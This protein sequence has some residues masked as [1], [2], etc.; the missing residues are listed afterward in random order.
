M[1]DIREIMKKI[2]PEWTIVNIIGEGSFATVYKAVREDLIGT[3]YAAIKVTRI[4]RDSNEIDSL[5]AEGLEPEK[6]YDYYQGVVKDYSAEIKLMD[7]VKGYTNIVAIDD[8]RIYQPEDRLIWYIFIRMELLT[9]LVKDVARHGIDEDR[10]IRLGIDLCT[11][12]DVCRQ[13]N[14]VHRDIKPENIFVN[15]NGYF[16]LGDFGVARNLEKMTNGLSLKG[17]PNYMA[18]EVAKSI[19]TEVDFNSAARID[20]Y[21]LGMVMYWLANGSK[22]PFLPL[23]KQ[24]ASPEDRKNA[25]IRRINGETL[26]LP[27]LVSPELQQII[28]KACSYDPGSRYRSAYD[29]KTALFRLQQKRE[30][31]AESPEPTPPPPPEENPPEKPPEPQPPENPPA[32]TYSRNSFAYPGGDAPGGS[33]KTR[34]GAPRKK[35][36]WLIL[37]PVL[38]LVLGVLFYPGF[39]KDDGRQGSLFDILISRLFA[40]APLPSETSRAS[41]DAA[42]YVVPGFGINRTVFSINRMDLQS[43]YREWKEVDAPFEQFP[44]RNFRDLPLIPEVNFVSRDILDY[45]GTEETNVTYFYDVIT[46]KFVQNPPADG[47]FITY[48]L[49][50]YCP[51]TNYALTRITIRDSSYYI[52]YFSVYYIDGDQ[53]VCYGISVSI[54]ESEVIDSTSFTLNYSNKSTYPDLTLTGVVNSK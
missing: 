29:M 13:H 22:L 15:D 18:P 35:K 40:A 44:Y 14:I 42:K 48:K 21:S 6:T 10:I 16:K 26:P 28:L 32:I 3:S 19:I 5:H 41:R 50:D 12:L 11:A 39:Q 31:V 51:E 38:L 27:R 33:G 36:K 30:A 1:D 53:M 17:T 9:P 34:K 7:S 52:T 54:G 23:N 24:I 20:I 2:W 8:Y 43:I 4:P 46:E 25:F 45:F 47:I 49:I 37:I